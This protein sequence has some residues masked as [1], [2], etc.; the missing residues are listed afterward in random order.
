VIGPS[1]SAK[2]QHARLPPTPTA[3]TAQRENQQARTNPSRPRR[4]H[5]RARNLLRNA[6]IR[7]P[8][9][10]FAWG[11][12]ANRAIARQP[13]AGEVLRLILRPFL[14]CPARSNESPLRKRHCPWRE[15]GGG[16]DCAYEL[17]PVRRCGTEKP[18]SWFSFP[19][20]SSR[21]ICCERPS[22]VAE[23]YSPARFSF[24][25]Q[26]RARK[27][28]SPSGSLQ[29]HAG[30]YR[31]TGERFCCFRSDRPQVAPCLAGTSACDT[32]IDGNI[33]TLYQRK[34]ACDALKATQFLLALPVGVHSFRESEFGR[35]RQC[36]RH[37]A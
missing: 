17:S 37:R 33:C 23:D 3:K 21:R 7:Q 19:L 9:G 5:R 6:N 2:L 24:I 10:R 14:Q 12:E 25:S 28:A 13:V 31:S 15:G 26:L 18:N 4:S 32:S 22:M 16:G 34:S 8:G 29:A 36:R 1:E 35:G 11:R 20:R 27:S 30:A